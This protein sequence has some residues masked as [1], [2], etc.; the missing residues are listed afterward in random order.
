MKFKFLFLFLLV[1]SAFVNADEFLHERDV[2]F[3]ISNI[4]MTTSPRLNDYLAIEFDLADENAVALDNSHIHLKVYDN[5]GRMIHDYSFKY[6]TR[7]DSALTIQ[8]L[9]H[10]AIERS[11]DYEFFRTIQA[12]SSSGSNT[13]EYRITSDDTGHVKA[14]L[15]LNA[16]QIGQTQ[17]CYFQ[18][19]DYN[20]NILQNNLDQQETFII[21]A[22][23]TQSFTIVQWGSFAANNIDGLAIIGFSLLIVLG[24][25]VIVGLFL[26]KYTGLIK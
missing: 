25:F 18:T 11:Q 8:N 5:Q 19:G 17:N 10:E 4:A 24:L 14:L 23:K 20:V 2:T 15:F 26:L 1:L 12:Q 13:L 22:E 9:N 6:I 7:S 16:C 3:S 21:G